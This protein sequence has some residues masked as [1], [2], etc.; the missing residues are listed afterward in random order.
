MCRDCALRPNQLAEDSC[1][2]LLLGTQHPSHS[3]K[4]GPSTHRLAGESP[5]F[6]LMAP[7]LGPCE[8]RYGLQESV[9]YGQVVTGPSDVFPREG[10]EAWRSQQPGWRFSRAVVWA[11]EN[12]VLFPFYLAENSESCYKQDGR[13]ARRTGAGA[14]FQCSSSC[15]LTSLKGAAGDVVHAGQGLQTLGSFISCSAQPF[16]AGVRHQ[17]EKCFAHVP[18][19]ILF[20]LAGHV[21]IQGGQCR[22]TAQVPGTGRCL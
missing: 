16:N 10:G 8:W 12:C 2:S 18:P 19:L 22:F 13:P 5:A 4:T 15:P 14:V 7:T 21:L 6:K 3:C 1:L 17:P 20:K 9:E 11:E